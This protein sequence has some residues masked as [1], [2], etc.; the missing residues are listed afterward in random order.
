M[1]GIDISSYLGNPQTL[2]EEDVLVMITELQQMPWCATYRMLVA[3]GYDNENSYLKNKH[4]RLA[5]TYVGDR[6]QLF[7]LMYDQTV[8]HKEEVKPVLI[9]ED[10]I[11][12]SEVK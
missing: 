12:A 8:L 9:E 5:S 4:L 11:E 6:E 1:S 10:P 2:Q 3:K 7:T